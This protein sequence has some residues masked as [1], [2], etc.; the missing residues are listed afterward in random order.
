M[1]LIKAIVFYLGYWSSTILYGLLSLPLLA[2]P[3]HYGAKVMLS[4][5][6]FIIWWLKITCNVRINITGNTQFPSGASVIVANHQSPWE[7]FFFQRY[8]SPLTTILKKELLNIPFFGWGLRL[9]DPMAIDRSQPFQSLKQIQEMSL[10]RLALGKNVLIFPEGTRM[11]VDQLGEYKRS[12]ADIAKQAG[13]PIIP[14]A[15]NSGTHWLNKK[16]IKLPGVI[17]VVIGEPIF[18]E[19]QSTKV[20]IKSI[21]Q[22]TEQQQAILNN[23]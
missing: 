2:L 21:Q 4:W 7:T 1:L 8:F 3:P 16:L 18:I 12:A 20:V 6:D 9:M 17:Q 19:Q 13:V 22:W 14:I 23:T 11:P 15:H 10:Q 5:N